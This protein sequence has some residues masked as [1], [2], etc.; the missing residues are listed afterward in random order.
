MPSMFDINKHWTIFTWE[1]TPGLRALRPPIAYYDFTEN[2]F[3]ISFTFLRTCFIAWILPYIDLTIFFCNLFSKINMNRFQKN[4]FMINNK[5]IDNN[6][7]FQMYR[8]YNWMRSNHSGQEIAF[9]IEFN[10]I[11]EKYYK[12]SQ[13]T[14]L[15]NVLDDNSLR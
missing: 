14:Y 11:Q 1:K 10:R 7:P 6:L 9:T 3:P 8:I 13:K 15:T 4:I 12:H 2:L 5:L